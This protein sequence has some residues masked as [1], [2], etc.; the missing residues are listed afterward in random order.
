[1]RSEPTYYFILTG[2]STDKVTEK[3]SVNVFHNA[4]CIHYFMPPP[5]KYHLNDSNSG[6]NNNM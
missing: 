3:K 4:K 1:M 5:C 2:V 6:V